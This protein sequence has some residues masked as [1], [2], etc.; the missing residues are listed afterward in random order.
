MLNGGGKTGPGKGL[1]ITGPE[2]NTARPVVRVNAALQ[3][4]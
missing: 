3:E 4:L 2:E 1:A